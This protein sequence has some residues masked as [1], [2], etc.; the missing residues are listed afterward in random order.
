M[1]QTSIEELSDLMREV[2]Q[3]ELRNKDKETII[4]VGN[5]VLVS[6]IIPK[7]VLNRYFKLADFYLSLVKED[8]SIYREGS[9]EQAILGQAIGLIGRLK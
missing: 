9:K 6:D 4:G 7:E 5:T 1:T 3:S 8:G 2:E